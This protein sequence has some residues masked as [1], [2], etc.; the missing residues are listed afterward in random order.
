MFIRKNWLPLSVFLIAIV[1]V[2]LYV[3][4]T[5]SPEKAPI[6]IYKTTEVEKPKAEVPVGDT[7][8]GGHF[9]EDGTWH[10]QPHAVESQQQFSE[11]EKSGTAAKNR[12]GDEEDWSDITPEQRAQIEKMRA[13]QLA[14]YVEKWGEPPSPDASY[15]HFRDNHGNVLRHYEGTVIVSDY[16]IR[17]GFAPTPAEL[18]HYKELKNALREATLADEVN[19]GSW[20]N[21]SV[22]VQRL[23][24]AIQALVEKA[25][26]EYPDPVGFGYYGDPI[27]PEIEKMLD[28]V[29]L[30]EF[31]KRMGVE[32]LYEL[33][34]ESN[35]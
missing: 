34:G 30:R 12:S 13:Q 6:K 28:K 27:S 9:H 10:A 15:Q 8:Q 23:S 32:H 33:Y 4:Q 2:G 29:A 11:G 20:E 31:Y 21:P 25:Q 35:Y 7:S 3:L 24:N 19:G 26:R 16:E 1:M 5:R 22:E 17:I 14:G 18:E